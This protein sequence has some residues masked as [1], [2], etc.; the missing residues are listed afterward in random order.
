MPPLRPS[1]ASP[2]AGGM[3]RGSAD[4]R[5]E[6]FDNPEVGTNVVDR[7]PSRNLAGLDLE[8][9]IARHDHRS[10]R[11]KSN[12]PRPSLLWL[13]E[14]SR[15]GLKTRSLHNG[16][17]LPKPIGIRLRQP[18]GIASIRQYHDRKRQK[19]ANRPARPRRYRGLRRLA[20]P[21]KCLA[22]RR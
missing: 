9:G 1:S 17:N 7:V 8:E 12:L 20:E 15:T 6:L 3:S 10:V 2:G 14:N 19:P 13:H 21:F 4:A 11:D 18:A 16:Q 5:P 22:I